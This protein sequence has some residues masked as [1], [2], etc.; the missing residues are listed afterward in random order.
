[1]SRQNIVLYIILWLLIPSLHAA[2]EFIPPLRLEG[3]V[4]SVY[5]ENTA[6][7][8]LVGEEISL[9]VDFEIVDF[10]GQPVYR[11][12]LRSRRIK[13][14]RLG[15]GYYIIQVKHQKKS[16]SRS[17]T[18]IVD[19][20]KRM[21]SPK[22][23]YAFDSAQSWLAVGD[24]ANRLNTATVNELV[25]QLLKLSGA[26]FV[27][28]RISWGQIQKQAG[29]FPN[30]CKRYD[31]NATLLAENGIRVLNVFHDAPSW[32]KHGSRTL[33]DDL[34]AVYEF[35]RYL[36]RHF[37]GRVAAWEFWNE[38]D[39]GFCQESGWD[40]AAAHKA[41]YLGFKDGDVT[42]PVLLGSFAVMPPSPFATCLFENGIVDYF[43]CA[44]R[45]PW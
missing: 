11:G 38:M 43:V 35:C 7:I 21:V 40:Y 13:L 16:F 10:Y 28:D 45:A 3:D 17:F 39:I 14:P 18:I 8:L 29:E 36:A 4:G 20:A 26:N 27:R 31:Q 44:Q 32:T 42:V 30:N 22:M 5:V 9:P 12:T 24:P 23:P 25:T 19:P 33:P 15:C 6:P 37:Q 41:A 1:M 34:G 2:G